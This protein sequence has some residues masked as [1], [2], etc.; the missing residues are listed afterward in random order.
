VVAALIAAAGYSYTLVPEVWSTAATTEA[1]ELLKKPAEDKVE[2][3]DLVFTDVL[4]FWSTFF[5]ISLMIGLALAMPVIIYQILAFVGPGLTGAEKR[6]VYPIVMGASAMFVAGCA[7]AYYVEMPP[8]LNFLL[9]APADLA[10]PLISVQKYVGFATKLMIVTGLVF[11]T[12]LVVMGLAKLGV[13]QSR[14]LLRWWRFALVGAFVISAIVTPSIDPITQTV[15]AGP[16]I[17]LYFVGA[18]LA[19]LVEKNP[20]IAR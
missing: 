4:E 20:L 19:R 16:M 13:V 17:I 1:L 15:V 12:P 11:E 2:N 18:G 10:T 14:T 5:R 7:F 9:N 3:F 8:A 6:W